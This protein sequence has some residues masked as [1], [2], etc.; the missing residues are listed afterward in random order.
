MKKICILLS[1]CLL[2]TGCNKVVDVPSTTENVTIEITSEISTT[3]TVDESTQTTTEVNDNLY[4]ASNYTSSPFV[5]INNNVPF[6]KDSDLTTTSFEFYSD[7]DELGRC[8]EAYACIGTDI[9][10]TEKRGEIGHIKPSGWH[11]VKYDKEIIS[12][13]Y[14]YNRCHLIAF[15]LAGENDN[16]LNLITGTRYMNVTGMLP[17]EDEVHDYL[18]NNPSNHVMYR[19]TPIFTGNNLVAEGVLM[20]AYSVEDNGSGV[21]FCVFCYNVQPGITIDYAT[22]ESNLSSDTTV[23]E[24]TTTEKSNNIETFVL[25]TNSGKFHTPDCE[26]V[27][28]M[29]EKNKKEITS[30]YDDMINNGYTPCK[31]CLDK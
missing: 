8:G 15:M 11:T 5:E 20:E 29:S 17:F 23:V 4:L 31:N 3:E 24:E 6:F 19:V 30:T 27:Q 2:L 7:L 16:E 10:P 28:S 26:S 21:K 13:M 25:N 12:D 18:I 9:M 22:G 1:L 14:L